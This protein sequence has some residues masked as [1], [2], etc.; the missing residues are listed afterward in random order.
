M[1]ECRENFRLALKKLYNYSDYGD[2]AHVDK[3]QH[4][5]APYAHYQHKNFL[6]KFADYLH[7]ELDQL[8]VQVANME[9][10]YAAD[11]VNY[12]EAG[13]AQSAVSQQAN[14]DA[15]VASEASLAGLSGQL[16]AA[17]AATQDDELIALQETRVAAEAAALSRADEL[18]KEIIYA[19]HVLQYA[20]NNKPHYAPAQPNGLTGVD[21]LDVRASLEYPDFEHEH[22]D[23]Y[24]DA[25]GFGYEGY[26]THGGYTDAPY[27]GHGY[28]YAQV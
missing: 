22:G 10:T 20:T 21:E 17:Y 26:G 25:H 6:Y 8:D 11:V 19:T 13:A 16:L 23:D 2:Y 27:G 24:V 7:E 15:R 12:S 1:A 5:Y 28:G 18:K 14:I 9:P 4:T 3:H